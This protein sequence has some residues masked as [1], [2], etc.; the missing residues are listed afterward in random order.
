[1]RA[2]QWL[3]SGNQAPV[4][5]FDGCTGASVDAARPAIRCGIP[6]AHETV[7]SD[8]TVSGRA[9]RRLE[10]FLYSVLPEAP[11]CPRST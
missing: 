6:E 7:S 9:L 4:I 8:W 3:S 11:Q 5:R 1:M 10:K 2:L